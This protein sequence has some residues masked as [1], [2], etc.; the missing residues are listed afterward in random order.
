MSDNGTF[1]LGDRIMDMK[2]AE[3]QRE[4]QGYHV[5]RRARADRAGGARFYRTALSQM[6]QR[7]VAWGAR[8]QERYGDENSSPKPA[9]AG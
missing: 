8:L 1:L 9:G 7:L 4:V 3:A 2:V 6:G 5:Q